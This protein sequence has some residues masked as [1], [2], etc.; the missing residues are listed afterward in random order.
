MKKKLTPEDYACLKGKYEKSVEENGY[1][2]ERIEKL[3][4]E[5]ECLI[6]KNAEYEY[7]TKKK[8]ES[9]EYYNKKNDDKSEFEKTYL[10][11]ANNYYELKDTVFTPHEQRVFY[12]LNQ[13]FYK[14]WHGK[15]YKIFPKIRICD[16]ISGIEQDS[17]DKD[18]NG[19]IVYN[20]TSKHVD[21]L[22]CEMVTPSD[23]NGNPDKKNTKYAPAFILEVYGVSH[24]NNP[25]TKQNDDFKEKL[26]GILGIK[27]IIVKNDD[28]IG[29]LKDFAD[30]LEKKI[31]E[32][33]F[34]PL[35]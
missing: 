8:V 29:I 24:H 9:K 35:M 10:E 5:K 3:Y 7:D 2:R 27:Q 6:R 1:L 14:P 34:L 15:T 26:F 18:L 21:F 31:A 22:L 16:F 20:I 12:C 17:L 25:R 23:S 11:N 13:I 19:V 28:V 4:A 30:I 33:L 32:E